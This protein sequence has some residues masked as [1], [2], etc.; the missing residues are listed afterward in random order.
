MIATYLDVNKLT[1]YISD[2]LLVEIQMGQV[3][4]MRCKTI[5]RKNDSMIMKKKDEEMM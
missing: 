3:E 2:R 4:L 5:K 1:N